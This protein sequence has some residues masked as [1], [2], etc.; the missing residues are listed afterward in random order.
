LL[1]TGLIARVNAA[2]HVQLPLQSLFEAP[3]VAG[4]AEA[5]IK[6]E[7][8]SGQ[9]VKIAQLRKKI[10]GMSSEEIRPLL[11]AKKKGGE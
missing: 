7:T 1:A 11:Q 9:I 8:V 3:T 4:Q 2:F 10:Q 5:L 6:H